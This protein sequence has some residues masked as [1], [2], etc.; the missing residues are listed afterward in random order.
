MGTKINVNH[1]K[2]TGEWVQHVRKSLKKYLNKKRRNYLKK[3]ENEER[4]K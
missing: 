4:Y 1:N 3:L 2:L